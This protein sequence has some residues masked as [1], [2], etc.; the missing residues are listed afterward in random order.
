MISVKV[1]GIMGN[2]TVK[3]KDLEVLSANNEMDFSWDSWQSYRDMSHEQL[4]TY[5]MQ[6]FKNLFDIL[7]ESDKSV[8]R[9]RHLD[10][11]LSE[12][13]RD[14]FTRCVI[15]VHRYWWNQKQFNE[16][17]VLRAFCGSSKKHLVI[18]KLCWL[19]TPTSK[20]NWYNICNLWF[21][22]IFRDLHVAD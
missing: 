7:N 14:E 8:S 9:I 1:P 10:I 21:R 18:W 12:I 3:P 20:E 5:I 16:F 13:Y 6:E 15:Y 2:Q 17:I 19:K 11:I 4:S 22:T